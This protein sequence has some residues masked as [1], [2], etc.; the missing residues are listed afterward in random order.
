MLRLSI[1]A[2]CKKINSFSLVRFQS[3]VTYKRARR[4]TLRRSAFQKIHRAGL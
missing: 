4:L 3:S 1:Q 2:E